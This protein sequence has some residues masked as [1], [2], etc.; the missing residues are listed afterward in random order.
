MRAMTFMMHISR[1][2]V[3]GAFFVADCF[4][5]GLARLRALR[6]TFVHT[7]PRVRQAFRRHRAALD[8]PGLPVSENT[9]RDARS[10]RHC[11]AFFGSV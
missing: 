10:D 8:I 1:T 6:P 7:Y 2:Y 11:C 4:R 9:A 3:V 5:G